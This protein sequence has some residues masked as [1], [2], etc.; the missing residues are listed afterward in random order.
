V[1]WGI[2]WLYESHYS[3]H[4]PFQSRL[5]DESSLAAT[6]VFSKREEILSQDVMPSREEGLEGFKATTEAGEKKRWPAAK[7]IALL[8][9]NW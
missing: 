2:E 8:T 9:I 7:R 5:G 6:L 1:L 3:V 4:M